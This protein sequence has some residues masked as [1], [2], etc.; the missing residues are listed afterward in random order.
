M[1][2]IWDFQYPNQFSITSNFFIKFPS[3]RENFTPVAIAKPNWVMIRKM[4][5]VL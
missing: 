3:L 5:K 2:H 1:E 4:L